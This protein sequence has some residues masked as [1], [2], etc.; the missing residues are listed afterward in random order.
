MRVAVFGLGEAGSRIAADLTTT[1]VEVDGYDPADVAT[2]DGVRRHDDPVSAVTDPDFVLSITASVD[3]REAMAQAWDSIGDEVVYV[4]MATSSPGLK[5]ELAEVAAEKGVPFVDVALM[6]PVPGQ[7][8]STPMLASGVGA[9]RL[10]DALNP[11]GA[12]VEVIGGDAGVAA[13]RKLTRSVVTKGLAGLVRESLV[14]ASAAGDGEWAWEHIVDLLSNTN[15]QFIQR[16][17]EGTDRHAERRLAEM[18]AAREYLE[19]LG[20][21][22]D[23]T[24]GTIEH[25]RRAL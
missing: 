18:A 16:L 15:E 17:I 3:S 24:S 6:A 7:G 25:L 22:F 19:D 20:V 21:P 14:A 12:K 8:L 1:G 23:M 11:L 4:D 2:P 10:A 9:G 5:R 13:A